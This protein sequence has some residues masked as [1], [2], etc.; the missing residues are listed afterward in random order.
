M[1]R[2]VKTYDTKTGKTTGETTLDKVQEGLLKLHEIEFDIGPGIRPKTVPCKRCAAI[3]VVP[4]SGGIPNWCPGCRK[5]SDCPDCGKPKAPKSQRCRE[6]SFLQSKAEHIACDGCGKHITSAAKK[7]TDRARLCAQCRK[8]NA[9]KATC[10]QCGDPM[11]GSCM[12]PSAVAKRKGKPPVCV[13]CRR[14]SPAFCSDCKQALPRNAAS[15]AQSRG[16]EKPRCQSCHL[17]HRKEEAALRQ[18]RLDAHCACE[19]G[20]V[21]NRRCETC[22]RIRCRVCKKRLPTTLSTAWVQR[23]K[24]HG[25]DPKDWP[26]PCCGGCFN[27]SQDSGRRK[28]RQQENR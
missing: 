3:V 4:K 10:S 23:Q 14:A 28:K 22:G 5:K 20:P 9:V 27:P 12:A 13:D 26:L 8:A 19:D 24:K 21:T 15:D 11:S 25:D 18:A 16:I 17:K 2:P 6:C 7:V 1:K